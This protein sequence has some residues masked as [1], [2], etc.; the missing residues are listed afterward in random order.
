MC[1]KLAREQHGSRKHHQ[2]GLLLLNKVLVGDLFCLTRYAGCYGM[3]DAKGCFDQIDHTFAILVLMFSG[4]PWAIART[5][6]QVLQRAKHSIKT[7]YGVSAPVY[8]NEDSAIAGIGQGNGLG[9]ALW[10]LISTI[11]IKMCKAKGHGMTIVTSISKK[12][13]LSPWFCIC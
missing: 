7:G 4:F 13:S 3:N 2:A 5:L 10:A 8:S 11:I 9:P 6:F 12:G 1:N